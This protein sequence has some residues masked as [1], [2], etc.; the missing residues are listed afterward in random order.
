MWVNYDI[1]VNVLPAFFISG[2]SASEVI[3]EMAYLRF[4]IGDKFTTAPSK[5]E[6]Q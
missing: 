3:H 6:G 1:Q 2:E 4:S 5:L